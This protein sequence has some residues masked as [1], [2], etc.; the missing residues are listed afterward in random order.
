MKPRTKK[1]SSLPF[2]AN[3]KRKRGDTQKYIISIQYQD[4]FV[5]LV[6]MNFTRSV[7]YMREKWSA[8][9]FDSK[10]KRH[11]LCRLYYYYCSFNTCNWVMDKSFVYLCVLYLLHSV[12]CVC[13]YIS[14]C[15]LPCFMLQ[16]RSML[17]LRVCSLVFFF[18][19]FSI[20]SFFL[21]PKNTYHFDLQKIV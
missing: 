7:A 20:L 18:F 2:K 11:F 1:V 21:L 17:I 14:I 3:D 8:I 15:H 10:K 19:F 4:S 13:I 9:S 6:E 12:I 16:L 5:L